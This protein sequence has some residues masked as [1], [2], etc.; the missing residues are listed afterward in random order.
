MAAAARSDDSPID[1]PWSY[2]KDSF[3]RGSEF[4]WQ[5][6]RAAR[7]RGQWRGGIGQSG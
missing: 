4:E 5:T 6:A 2:V 1:L 7:V 3:K